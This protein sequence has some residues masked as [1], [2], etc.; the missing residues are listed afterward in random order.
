[1]KI[2]VEQQ[3]AA[4]W[5]NIATQITGRTPKQCRERWYHHL[6][7]NIRKGE[8]TSEEDEM[9]LKI[10]K[11]IGNQW[12]KISALLTGRADID[13]KNRFH[14]LQR[15]RFTPER[16][17][18]DEATTQYS[19]DSHPDNNDSF[20]LSPRSLRGSLRSTPEY[21]EYPNL[22]SKSSRGSLRSTPRTPRCQSY[23]EYD[24]SQRTS[25]CSDVPNVIPYYDGSDTVSQITKHPNEDKW[26]SDFSRDSSPRIDHAYTDIFPGIA[27][28]N[29][30]LTRT[31]SYNSSMVKPCTERFSGLP[32][33]HSL[34]SPS[35]TENPYIERIPS[36][37]LSLSRSF[38]GPVVSKTNIYAEKYPIQ[39]PYVPLSA[40]FPTNSADCHSTLFS[41]SSSNVPESNFVE[42]CQYSLPLVPE[43]DLEMT[44]FESES[45][46]TLLESTVKLEPV[47]A[48]APVL[49]VEQEILD[50]LASDMDQMHVYENNRMT[51]AIGSGLGLSNCMTDWDPELDCLD[52]RSH[53]PKAE[54]ELGGGLD[55]LPLGPYQTYYLSKC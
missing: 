13:V 54:V 53:S 40:I 24:G 49:F 50:F 20:D 22:S 55:L 43:P 9:I 17:E 39:T 32:L 4:N 41:K 33:N 38:S 31:T 26:Y 52:V 18:Y 2:I 27:S 37:H 44:D 36:R 51:A 3:G 25:I 21:N 15:V 8:W 47:Q 1:M 30:P 5:P 16:N 12:S 48:S 35:I 46:L 19:L 14:K 7:T 11:Q 28:N 34:I 23:D 29:A 42:E 45:A 6:D 10:Q